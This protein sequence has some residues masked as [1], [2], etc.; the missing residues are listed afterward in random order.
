MIL[1]RSWYTCLSWWKDYHSESSSSS[2]PNI[3][4]GDISIHQSMDVYDL[5]HSVSMPLTVI[6]NPSIACGKTNINQQP[7]Q[8]LRATSQE[9][10]QWT[11]ELTWHM[12]VS[13]LTE[14][15][16]SINGALPN[17]TKSIS[18][19]RGGRRCTSIISMLIEK[20]RLSP[21]FG[22]T[23]IDLE[24]ATDTLYN[25][26]SWMFGCL[27]MFDG[28]RLFFPDY[29]WTPSCFFKPCFMFISWNG[30]S[31]TF[32]CPLPKLVA[33]GSNC[34]NYLAILFRRWFIK[35]HQSF[36]TM[37]LFHTLCPRWSHFVR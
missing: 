8:L 20:E 7:C 34:I 31:V 5:F 21:Q 2:I 3:D 14:T 18:F 10:P 15:G 30:E 4:V 13:V 23:T 32:V 29:C 28:Q 11:V 12:G 37:T 36:T 1:E 26:G 17:V 6:T 33:Q 19:D 24:A 16:M 22:S 35:S 27:M 9:V 25:H